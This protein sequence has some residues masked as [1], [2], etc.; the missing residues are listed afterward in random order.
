MKHLPVFGL[1][2][3]LLIIP[4]ARAQEKGFPFCGE[5]ELLAMITSLLDYETGDRG[6]IET[7]ADLVERARSRLERR[8]SS[9]S[10]LPLCD[11]AIDT[12]RQVIML[13]GDSTGSLALEIAQIAAEANPYIQ[14]NLSFDTHL[15]ELAARLLG[16]AAD[17]AAAEA[18]RGIA[19]CSRAEC[20]A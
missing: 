5:V 6:I 2:L 9:L 12:Q 3:A 13:K 1:A 15:A 10:L 4:T 14:R 11:P 17:E 7:I 20:L 18:D 19:F 16:G 8:E